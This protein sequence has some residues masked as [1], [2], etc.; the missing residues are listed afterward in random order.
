[1]YSG[2]WANFCSIS[3]KVSKPYVAPN[4]D[5]TPAEFTEAIIKDFP[6]SIS[7]KNKNDQQP[8]IIIHRSK[9]DTLG[10]TF[11]Y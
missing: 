2:V 11:D 8:S 5:T 9:N 4:S 7:T 3:S 10:K 6:I 1:M